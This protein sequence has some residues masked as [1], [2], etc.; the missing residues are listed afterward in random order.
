MG[1]STRLNPTSLG[2]ALGHGLVIAWFF[3]AP[4]LSAGY[5]VLRGVPHSRLL[6]AVA[7]SAVMAPLLLAIAGF[8]IFMVAAFQCPPNAYECP[9]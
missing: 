7:V 4:S 3:F 2:I 9:V 1:E 6:I 8:V 5:L